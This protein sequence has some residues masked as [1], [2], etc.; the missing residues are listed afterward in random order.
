MQYIKQSHL[1]SQNLMTR[2]ILP[3]CT[4]IYTRFEYENN[5]QLFLLTWALNIL[6]DGTTHAKEFPWIL[7][8]DQ[9]KNR[10]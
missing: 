5:A 6:W 8:I 4:K 1:L 7:Q 9:Q 2:N 3:L 10:N